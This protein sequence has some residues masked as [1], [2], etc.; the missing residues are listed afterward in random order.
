M[1]G[2]TTSLSNV[3]PLTNAGATLTSKYTHWV[4][5]GLLVN[6]VI[7]V[8]VSVWSHARLDSDIGPCLST[9]PCQDINTGERN[10]FAYYFFGIVSLAL[11]DSNNVGA[12]EHCCIVRLATSHSHN[13]GS[14]CDVHVCIL[15]LESVTKVNILQWA[16]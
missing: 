8:L 10:L 15:A 7:V 1:I 5:I 11:V 12:S 13:S 16:L 14:F 4:F 3:Q 6:T 9:V 2:T